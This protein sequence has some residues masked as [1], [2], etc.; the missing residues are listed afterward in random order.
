ME[1]E[2][3]VKDAALGIAAGVR[4]VYPN[5]EQRDDCFHALY[6]MGKVYFTLERK[7]YSAIAKVEHAREELEKCRQTGRSDRARLKGK[8]IAVT[9]RCNQVIERHDLFEQAMRRAQQAMEVVDSTDGTLRSAEWIQSELEQAAGQMMALED[10]K[11]RKVGRY[12]SNR[13]AGLASHARQTA[14][15]ME[16]LASLWGRK[17]V[18]S[19]RLIHRLLTD[20]SHPHLAFRKWDARKQLATA[21]SHL[22][23]QAGKFADAVLA[24]VDLLMKFRHRASSAIEGFNASLRPHLY[25]QKGVSQGFLDL[26]R[27]HYN[28]KTRRWGRHKGTSAHE[29]VTGDFVEDWLTMLGFPPSS[30]VN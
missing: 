9:R 24:D 17:A 3:V 16:V 7:A 27:A 28:L 26:Y 18:Q 4:Q 25:V 19:A 8:L 22:R 6:E 11:C 20:L 1:L 15:H 10:T 2:T 29:M 12:L 23:Q 5:A 14:D 13:A 30:T 21:H